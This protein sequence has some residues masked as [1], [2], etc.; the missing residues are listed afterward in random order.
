MRKTA[1][2]LVFV[3]VL[4]LAGV[5][6]M[7]IWAAEQ[8]DNAE[9]SILEGLKGVSV[10]VVQPVS[11][12]ENRPAYN[13]VKVGQLHSTV[14]RL[15]NEAKIEVF[16][17]APNDPNIGHVAVTVNVWKTKLA[18]N[19]IAHV[20]VELYQQ[21]TVV[22][23]DKF[24]ILTPTWPLGAKAAEAPK[25]VILTH[26]QIVPTV[27][28]QIETQIKM[29]I[30]D[31]RKANPLPEPKQDISAVTYRWIPIPKREHGYGRMDSVVI[32]SKTELARLLKRVRGQGGWNNRKGFEE[33]IIRANVDFNR[34]VLVLLRHTE[35]SGS[36]QVT[37]HR[38]TVRAGTLT[39]RIT[40]KMP[41]VGTADM[42]Y[43]CFALAV[44]KSYVSKVELHVQGRKSTYMN[45][46]D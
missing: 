27:R 41:Q 40:R 6:E 26:H 25:P 44:S 19:F 42:A 32:R 21:A 13:P 20:K 43:Y 8:Q 28:Q 15:L 24:Q 34:E 7:P 16:D 23:D 3:A 35:G 1:S 12:F 9:I 33:A 10:E 18:I 37:F 11:G 31:Y 22:R 36:V 4:V 17:D 30:G 29:L 2:I 14:E 39:C 45:T 38:P 5:P 46:R